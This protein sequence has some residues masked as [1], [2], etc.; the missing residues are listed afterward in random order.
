MKQ[1]CQVLAFCFVPTIY[2]WFLVSWPLS[3]PFSPA[4]ALKVV[5]FSWF[6]FKYLIL[7]KLLIHFC[8]DK[9]LYLLF[10][11]PGVKLLESLD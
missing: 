4:L 1:S 10:N 2:V 9:I 6:D 7:F 8:E 3:L 11:Y 5:V